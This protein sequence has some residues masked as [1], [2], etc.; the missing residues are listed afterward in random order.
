T[1]NSSLGLP[2]FTEA[3]GLLY[4]TAHN[5]SG[6]NNELWRV[7]VRRQL[8]IGDVTVNEAAGTATVT[9]SATAGSYPVSFDYTTADDTALVDLD[10]SGVAGSKTIPVGAGSATV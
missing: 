2:D 5:D 8:S 10:Y 4:F 1:A 6:L 7:A 3:G 9:V